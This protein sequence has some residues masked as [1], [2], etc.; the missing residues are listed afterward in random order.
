MCSRS[1]L[2]PHISGQYGLM[3]VMAE[4]LIFSSWMIS[5][6]A[7]V[8]PDFLLE[9]K[10]WPYFWNQSQLRYFRDRILLGWKTH[11]TPSSLF[12]LRRDTYGLCMWTHPTFLLFQMTKA[13]GGQT[14]VPYG[15]RRKQCFSKE[16]VKRKKDPLSRFFQELLRND[17]ILFLKSLGGEQRKGEPC[18]ILPKL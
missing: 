7:K 10:S 4:F 15:L 8:V 16:Y 14:E 6:G 2:G 11:W 12:M 3:P 17:I 1:L 18:E 9:S 13:L 5:N